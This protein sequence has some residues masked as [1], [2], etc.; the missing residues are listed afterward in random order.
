MAVGGVC[1]QAGQEGD[2]GLY[3]QK[4]LLTPLVEVFQ[5]SVPPGQ[6]EAVLHELKGGE[7]SRVRVDAALS[8]PPPALGPASPPP[9]ARG[10][11]NGRGEA[12]GLR[13]VRQ[14]CY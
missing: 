14:G 7:H 13:A 8:P 12:P 9:R 5:A 2:Y 4:K 3:W 11:T 6:R 10:G 1:V